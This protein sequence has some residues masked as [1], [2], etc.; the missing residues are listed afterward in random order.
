MAAAM[1]CDWLVLAEDHTSTFKIPAP[2]SLFMNTNLHP[3]SPQLKKSNVRFFFLFLIGNIHEIQLQ[4]HT[5][6]YTW[7]EKD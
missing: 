2:T 5:S 4:L 6:V 3:L 1:D 7:R